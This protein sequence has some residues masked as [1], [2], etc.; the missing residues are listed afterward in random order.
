MEGSPMRDKGSGKKR[1]F[2]KK[3]GEAIASGLAPE[4]LGREESGVKF[5]KNFAKPRRRSR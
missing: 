5:R 1:D 4:E 3:V 2:P